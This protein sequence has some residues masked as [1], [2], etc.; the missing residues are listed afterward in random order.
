MPK[1]ASYYSVGGERMDDLKDK[2]VTVEEAAVLASRKTSLIRVLCRNGRLP[3]AVKMGNSWII[4]KVDVEAY[5]P[6]KRGVKSHKGNLAAE[7]AAILAEAKG[8]EESR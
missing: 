1:I 2:Y 3:G 7:R 5:K 8:K 4:P 6:A